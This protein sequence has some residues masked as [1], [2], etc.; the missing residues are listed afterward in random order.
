[1]KILMNR[2]HIKYKIL[3]VKI[4]VRKYWTK[5]YLLLHLENSKQMGASAITINHSSDFDFKDLMN[6]CKKLLVKPPS[7]LVNNAT[8]TL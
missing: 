6:S 7:F 1:M 3:T 8:L 4:S 2:I 5:F